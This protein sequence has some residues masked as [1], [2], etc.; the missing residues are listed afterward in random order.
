MNVL[1]LSKSMKEAGLLCDQSSSLSYDIGYIP[2]RIL[3]LAVAIEVCEAVFLCHFI[4]PLK[5]RF[6]TQISEIVQQ[7]FINRPTILQF[8]PINKYLAS[9]TQLISVF[10]YFVF[11]I[12]LVGCYTLN[13]SYHLTNFKFIT[14]ISSWNLVWNDALNICISMQFVEV[15][16]FLGHICR[17]II[18]NKLIFVENNVAR[19]EC[20]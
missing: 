13:K 11:L 8:S 16:F 15:E 1:C 12:T 5:F 3:C 10:I 7:F 6:S 19:H 9:I 14:Q 20:C 4:F 18:L 2:L 17:F